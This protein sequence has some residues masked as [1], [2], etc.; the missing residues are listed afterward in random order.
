MII[1]VPKEVKNNEFR[2]ALTPAGA[3]ALA[4]AGHEVL[5]ERGAGKGS[6]FADEE[7]VGAGAKIA[8]DAAEV[9]GRADL[10]LKVKEPQPEEFVHFRE[11]QMLF[12][13]LHLAAAVPLA[14]EL[15]R[16]R[17]TAIAYETV[18]LD[19][20]AL[21]L[22]T[23]MSEVAG[24]MS[25]Q[26]G[27]QFLEAFHGGRGVLLGGI[28]GVPP[29]DVVIVGGGTVGT[30]A[31]KM[32]LGLGASVTVLDKSADRLRAL[33]DL[34]LG[35]VTTLMSNAYNIAA[36]VRKADL[37]IGAVLIPGAKAPKLV[38][39][40]MVKTMKAGAV[41]VD[42]AVDQGG[43]VETVDRVTTHSDPVYVKHGVVHY[44]VSNIP[45]A[46]PRTSTLGLTNVTLPYVL[47]LAN[48]GFERAVRESVPLSRGVN[49]HAGQIVHEAVARDVGLP[50]VPLTET[51][52]VINRP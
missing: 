46:V 21:P 41:I 11:G 30:N 39:E 1:G 14:H 35:R 33:D 37:L 43:S 2:V 22:L 51:I 40:E 4:A 23:P 17:V 34:F 12:T 19:S 29:A 16:K 26:V 31:A 27:A 7:F 44:A 20:G 45:G 28:P 13:Y 8:V 9:W 25:V 36:A 38:T 6:G 3:H 15:V 47:D 52:S 48:K 42:V 24:R 49:A 5:V 50:Y 10:V 32:A 18:Q